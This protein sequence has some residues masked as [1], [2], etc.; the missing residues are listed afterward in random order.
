MPSQLCYNCAWHKAN[1][2]SLST[3]FCPISS[4][5][6]DFSSLFIAHTQYPTRGVIKVPQMD[7]AIG[8]YITCDVQ[9]YQYLHTVNLTFN[10]T[11]YPSVVRWS[12]NQTHET[13]WRTGYSIRYI[14]YT[15][16]SDKRC[17]DTSIYIV[18]LPGFDLQRLRVDIEVRNVS[19]RAKVPE[20]GHFEII[21]E[22]DP[23]TTEGKEPTT[24]PQTSPTTVQGSDTTSSAPGHAVPTAIDTQRGRA[25]QS[26]SIAAIVL[27]AL[28]VLALVVIA[29]LIT[30]I[31]RNS[32]SKAKKEPRHV[33]TGQDTTDGMHDDENDDENTPF[34]TDT[35]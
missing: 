17:L 9:Q 23:V 10:D 12:T 19:N 35:T 31:A 28:L 14:E 15:S 13:A 32:I 22:S 30:I 11:Q 2:V 34:K 8:S 27:G 24:T 4:S 7:Q 33:P 21:F 5:T 6:V 1:S 25:Q 18:N 26:G 3:A 29:V 16:E 20:E